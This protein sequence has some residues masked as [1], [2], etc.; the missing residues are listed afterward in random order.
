MKK[1]SFKSSYSV[2]LL[3]YIGRI[4]S[5][6]TNFILLPTYL[7]T[8]SL[9][10]YAGMHHM[11]FLLA[12]I[13]LSQ[14]ILRYGPKYDGKKGGQA[15]FLGWVVVASTLLYGALI[16]IAFFFKGA[17]ITY[18]TPKAADIIY[19]LPW[20]ALWGYVVLLNVTLKAYAIAFNRVFWPSFFQHVVLNVLL[21]G[22]IYGYG[23][24]YYGFDLFLLGM[25]CAYGINLL[26]LCFDLW[27]RGE[28]R[29]SWD[30]RFFNLSF[31][32][33][34]GRYSMITLVSG[35]LSM[36]M[37]RI[38][39][40]MVL[41]MCGKESETLYHSVVFLG[42]LLEIP[43]KVVKQTWGAHLVKLL[44]QKS[45]DD[46]QKVYKEVTYWQFAS[47]TLCFMILYTYIDYLLFAFSK[48][49]LAIMKGLFLCIGLSK[50]IDNIFRLGSEI[51]I[52]SPY[53]TWGIVNALLLLLGIGNNYFMI[54]W[55]GVLG[56][57]IAT[58]MTLL[59][60]GGFSLFLIWYKLKINPWS[61]QLAW[62]IGITLLGILAIHCLPICSSAYVDILMRTTFLSLFFCST[63]VIAKKVK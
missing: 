34:F 30:S 58:G 6:I 15:A 31:M 45:Y 16:G 25:A 23:V 26:L 20:V 48:E 18:F 14:G 17:L 60:G 53:F 32:R 3:N 2:L 24:G 37:L 22:I 21:I 11:V 59:L 61:V 46:L 55:I 44:N 27:Q 41:A 5:A 39:N 33:S 35:N 29:L 10:L 62:A 19:Y 40:I 4:L 7:G 28:L 12:K 9:G 50:L 51:V 52:L 1:I 54:R 56:A 8:S 49:D 42:L 63:F 13:D 57:S 47:S 36:L 43:M 38:D